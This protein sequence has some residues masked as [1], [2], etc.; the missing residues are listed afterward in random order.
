MLLSLLI[1]YRVNWS[2]Y[3]LSLDN[4][5]FSLLQTQHGW[6]CKMNPLLV[7][8]HTE[9][10]LREV[11]LPKHR[12]SIIL[13]LL[14]YLRFLWKTSRYDRVCALREGQ[15]GC[16]GVPVVALGSAVRQLTPTSAVSCW[17]HSPGIALPLVWLSLGTRR[18]NVEML[19]AATNNAHSTL[20][21]K[22]T[23]AQL[24]I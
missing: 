6:I 12:S 5:S 21:Q 15:V 10:K 9:V 7:M 19:Y 1:L 24:P 13:H 4:C 11:L 22:L 18:D 2:P 3:E 20:V 23:H 14:G 8:D 17:M 16:P